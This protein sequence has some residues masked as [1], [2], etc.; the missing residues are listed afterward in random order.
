[1]SNKKLYTDEQLRAHKN[2]RTAQRYI[3]K[4]EIYSIY[5]QLLRL[6]KL[7]DP[8]FKSNEARKVREW[9]LENR[10]RARATAKKSRVKNSEKCKADN[11]AWFAKNP[12]KRAIYEQN[13]RAKKKSNGGRLT[14]GIKE[15]L[16]IAQR[17]L[18]ACCRIKLPII[19]MHM[20]H[21]TPLSLGGENDD[22][23][24]Q[25]LCQ[26]CNQTKYNKHPIDFMQG[27]GYLL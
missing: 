5:H 3:E 12:E 9:S 1:M 21:I 19:K 11:R 15:R 4:K 25:L 6:S 17:G 23:N 20:D 10:D 8:T 2:A 27:N 24:M 14:P 18:C 22:L 7:D 26:P 13:R 16:F